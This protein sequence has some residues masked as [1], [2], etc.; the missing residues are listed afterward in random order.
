MLVLGAGDGD[1]FDTGA[2]GIADGEA[3][4]EWLD[5]TVVSPDGRTIPGR[6]TVF[7]RIGSEPRV[8]G[9][10]DTAAIAPVELVDLDDELT[11]EYPPLRVARLIAVA[12]GT[13]SAE[14]FRGLGQGGD[15]AA[16]FAAFPY[17]YH[18][19][20]EAASGAV[21]LPRGVRSFIDRPNVVAYDLDLIPGS[22]VGGQERTAFG[23][24]LIA[25]S[26]G[27]LALV[28]APAAV[29]GGLLAGVLAHEAERLAAGDGVG[30]EVAPSR[31]VDSVGGVFEAAAALGVPLTVLRDASD[32]DGIPIGPD[33]ARILTTGLQD[34]MVAVIPVRPVELHGAERIG[35]WL[36]DPGTG[37]AVDVFEDGR[38]TAT[39]ESA[40][41]YDR[42]AMYVRKFV[43]LGLALK[44]IYTLAELV[45]EQ[46]T[47]FVIGVALGFPAH[48]FLGGHCH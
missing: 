32:V 19:G 2:G 15:D 37:E 27:Q 29:P 41:L 6:I 23:V 4:A 44:T 47:G 40:L 13:T 12:T 31:T 3:T 16:A 22:I 28:G 10:I 33:V 36:V 42:I 48:Y 7:D 34:G 11:G 14:R 45:L 39:T 17:L 26:T 35:W 21:A 38:G 1:I 46:Y 25:R 5:V 8:A 20:R 24:D 30:P 9:T 18:L 43:C